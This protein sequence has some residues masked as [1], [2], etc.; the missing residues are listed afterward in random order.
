MGFFFSCRAIA[1]Q[2]VPL[3][4]AQSTVF[5][6]FADKLWYG[7]ISLS[8]IFP[9]SLPPFKKHCRAVKLWVVS[10]SACYRPLISCS[11]IRIAQNQAAFF[12]CLL[13]F[14]FCVVFCEI[15][16]TCFRFGYSLSVKKWKSRKISE[17]VPPIPDY[18]SSA[19]A[20]RCG[21]AKVIARQAA[22]QQSRGFD[23]RHPQNCRLSH[24]K[25]EA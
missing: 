15:A 23:S 19:D 1:I 2:K 5:V 3:R 9:A 22:V 14:R 18:I 17:R 11:Y 24:I 12:R 6:L 13:L 20:V 10:G 4:F 21:V 25:E 8:L 7:A 16:L